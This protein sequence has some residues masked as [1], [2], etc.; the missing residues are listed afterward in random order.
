VF[1]QTDYFYLD[2]GEKVNFKTRRDKVILKT[3]SATEVQSLSK[4]T[5]LSS[6]NQLIEGYVIATLDTLQTKK[7]DLKQKPGVIDVSYLLEYADGTLQT[8]SDKIFVKPKKGQ[9]IEQFIKNAGLSKSRTGTELIIPEDEIYLV[10]LNVAIGDI[11][12][13]TRKLYESK[14]CEFAEPCFFKLIKPHNEF[15][16]QQWGLNNTGQTIGDVTGT[17]GIDIHSPSFSR[18]NSS[19]II[20]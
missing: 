5:G 2:N 11:L 4:Q 12:P 3:Q 9:T 1:A 20:R 18:N 13:L 16:P 10:T 17:S 19:K 7:D 14:L 15:Y 6:V 8:P